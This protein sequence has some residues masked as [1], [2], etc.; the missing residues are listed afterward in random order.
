MITKDKLVVVD[1]K[2]GEQI[3][4][5]HYNQVRNYLNLIRQMGYKQV[6]GYLWYIELNKIEEVKG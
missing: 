2:F 5:A 3:K 4:K 1:Y 6:E